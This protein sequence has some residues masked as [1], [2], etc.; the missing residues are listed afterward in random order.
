MRP[1][2]P[3]RRQTRSQVMPSMGMTTMEKAM[4][5]IVFPIKSK[6]F[7]FFFL[8]RLSYPHRLITSQRCCFSGSRIHKNNKILHLLC[9]LR[10]LH[11]TSLLS[12]ATRNVG[13]SLLAK[14]FYKKFD[15]TAVA[16]AVFAVKSIFALIAY[17]TMFIR[18]EEIHYDVYIPGAG[19]LYGYRSVFYYR[20]KAT[21][22]V[23]RP[24]C[25][26]STHSE[27]W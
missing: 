16:V 25:H 24:H 21:T 13:A 14:S 9:C 7:A 3:S 27:F 15:A 26:K 19:W 22:T 10:R 17:S 8:A 5:F 18:H 20:A 6:R 2:K 4:Q 23:A 11:W 12:V 1:L